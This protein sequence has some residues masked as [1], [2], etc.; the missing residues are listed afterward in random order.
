MLSPE[1]ENGAGFRELISFYFSENAIIFSMEELLRIL[2]VDAPVFPNLTEAF[3]SRLQCSPVLIQTGRSMV[4]SPRYDAR[5]FC[6]VD[7]LGSA[8]LARVIGPTGSQRQGS[9]G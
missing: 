1:V 3:L 9:G 2:V 7:P 6:F 5:N 8:E 4:P